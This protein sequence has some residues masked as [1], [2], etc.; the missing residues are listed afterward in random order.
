M[1]GVTNALIQGKIHDSH[2]EDALLVLAHSI[3]QLPLY[4]ERVKESRHGLPAT[5]LPVLNDLR[6]VRGESLLSETVLFS[7]ELESFDSSSSDLVEVAIT[8]DE[9]QEIAHKL[10]QMFQIALLG[11]IRSQEL[12]KNLNY[13]AKVC[14]RL[15]K[16]S[17]GCYSQP[18]WKVCIALLEGLLN[19]SIEPSISVKILLRQVDRELKFIVEKGESAIRKR[20]KEGLL[21]NLLYY[22]ARSKADS[23]YISEIKT[24]YKLDRSLPGVGELDDESLALPDSQLMQSMVEALGRELE[25]IKLALAQA[26]DSHSQLSDVL[27]LFKRVCDTMAV[28]GMGNVLKIVQEPFSQLSKILL[29]EEEVSRTDLNVLNEQIL[30]AERALNS[31]DLV[32]R[33][34]EE[35]KPFNDSEEAQDHLNKALDSIIRESRKNLEAAKEAVIEFVAT[36]WDHNSLVEM[37]SLLNSVYGSLKMAPFERAAS[38]VNSC[39]MFVT[40]ELL[41][42]KT[43]PAWQKLD[44]LADAITSIEYYLERIADGVDSESE[45]ILEVASESVAEL[46]YPVELVQELSPSFEQAETGLGESSSSVADSSFLT[47]QNSTDDEFAASVAT[48]DQLS[49]GDVDEEATGTK[50]TEINSNFLTDQSAAEKSVAAEN[51]EEVDPEIIEIFVEEAGEVLEAIAESLPTWKLNQSD[52]DS[53]STVRRAFH[54]LK[55]SGRMVGAEDIGDLSWSI[56]NMLNRISDGST[57]V[58][59]VRFDLID[60]VVSKIPEFVGAFENKQRVDRT[61]IE[62]FINCAEALAAEQTPDIELEHSG[63]FAG[64]SRDEENLSGSVEGTDVSVEPA[65]DSLEL[66]L[67]EELD[68]ELMEIFAAETIA[69]AQVLKSFI[70]HCRDQIGR[71]HV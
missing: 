24:Q 11:L 66:K 45:A 38:I 14:A 43:V 25:D 44:T 61:L 56:E 37:P 9:L 40:K 26:G 17:Q 71:A 27:P 55:G 18:L 15:V 4:L 68:A 8:G 53:Q 69:H 31:Y 6:A 67:D 35:E 12:K 64:D 1:E 48:N 33:Q 16:L 41:E 59:Q 22:I 28:L 20:P 3:A 30:L 57:E 42:N 13:L 39:N 21:K 51:E 65:T 5:L 52:T 10:R 70:D 54:T 49:V 60:K 36:Q 46:G 47:E 23:K 34:T 62:H 2:T 7:P 29:A 19:G 50:G 32:E 58:D 63:G